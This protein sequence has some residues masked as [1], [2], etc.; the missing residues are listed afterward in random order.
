MSYKYMRKIQYH[1][2][3]NP[4]PMPGPLGCL[5]TPLSF[6][7]P[8]PPGP[9]GPPVPGTPLVAPLPEVDLDPSPLPPPPPFETPGVPSLDTGDRFTW[10]GTRSKFRSAGELFPLCMGDLPCPA[11][12]TP[13]AAAAASFPNIRS[14]ANLYSSS[15]S[16]KLF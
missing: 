3:A 12:T 4:P 6:S 14:R 16:D 5:I 13:L 8:A 11:P 7:L 1:A 9:P 2:L 10:V 15:R